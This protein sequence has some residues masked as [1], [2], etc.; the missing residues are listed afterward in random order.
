MAET[1]HLNLILTPSGEWSTK[2]YN[3]FISEL[4]GDDGSSALQKIDSAIQVIDTE[5]SRLENALSV[6]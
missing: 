1:A 3:T 4:A 2:L 5:R 6:I